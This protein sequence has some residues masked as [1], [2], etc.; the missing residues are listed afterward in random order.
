MQMNIVGQQVMQQQVIPE[1]DD[2]EGAA[3]GTQQIPEDQLQQII[4]MLQE[5]Q[6]DIENLDPNFLQQILLA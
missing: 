4:Q 1:E 3:S 5:Q 2:E 6:V